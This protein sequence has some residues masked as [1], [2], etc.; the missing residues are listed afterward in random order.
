VKESGAERA[1]PF[2]S[3]SYSLDRALTTTLN[4][5][6]SQAPLGFGTQQTAN[7]FERLPGLPNIDERSAIN[8]GQAHWAAPAR[9]QQLRPTLERILQREGLPAQL[10]AVVLVESGGRPTAVSP[11]DARGLWQFIPATAQRYGHS[12]T[13]VRDDRLDAENATRA[14][15]RYLRDLHLRFGDWPLALA[16]YNAGEDA[17]QRALETLKGADFWRLSSKKLLPEETRKYV[18]A[19]LA[20]MRL[21]YRQGFE[22]I[23]VPTD[24]SASLANTSKVVYATSA[25]TD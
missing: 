4:R 23:A 25:V 1:D 18:P 8:L 12:V 24:S 14:A 10:S 16:A 6:E 2:A 5:L 15:A 17:V 22:A 7:G 19:V 13:P 3:Y 20:A 21:L 11:K 9:F